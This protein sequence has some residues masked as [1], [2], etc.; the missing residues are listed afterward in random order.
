MKASTP[1]SIAKSY[2]WNLHNSS[3]RERIGAKSIHIASIPNK[4]LME[5]RTCLASLEIEAQNQ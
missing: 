5:N 3:Q 1:L 4:Q 2:Q